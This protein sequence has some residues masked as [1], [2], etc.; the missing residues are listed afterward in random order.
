VLVAEDLTS[1][2]LTS[3][4][5]ASL[6]TLPFLLLSSVVLGAPLAVPAAIGLGY[7]AVAHALTGRHRRRADLITAVVLVGLVGWLLTFLLAGEGPLSHAGLVAALMAPVF[8]AAPAFAR[9]VISARKAVPETPGSSLRDTALERVACLD[10]L[11]PAEQVLVLDADG[12]V[13]AATAAARKALRML[14]DAFE[15]HLNSL[16][17]ADDLQRLLEAL[18]RSINRSGNVELEGDHLA[19]LY[20]PTKGGM[21]PPLRTRATAMLSATFSPCSDGS[22]A[23]RLR[24]HVAVKPAAV[25]VVEGPIPPSVSKSAKPC[26][27]PRCDIGEAVAFALR[28]SKQKALAKNMALTS[29]IEPNLAVACDRQIGRR[30]VSLLIDAALNGSASGS[31]VEIV[32]RRLKGVVILRASSEPGAQVSEGSESDDDR[33]DVTALRSLVER[34]GG[35]LVVD[36]AGNAIALCVR[37]DLAAERMTEQRMNARAKAQ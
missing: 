27:L 24:D 11:T 3:A 2:A 9:S 23:M 13:L 20:S 21:T 26:I 33:F 12:T 36:R 8:A 18:E 22:V 14:P 5:L 7:L 4:G 15:H 32:V 19:H 10:E 16:L 34:A 28:H 35:T 6:F 17:E 1:R 37:L 29:T 25:S 30:T 31:T